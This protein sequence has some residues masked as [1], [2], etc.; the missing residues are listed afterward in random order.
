M[1]I[2]Q[3]TYYAVLELSYKIKGGDK[4]N[5]YI[6]SYVIVEGDRVRNQFGK[7]LTISMGKDKFQRV[8]IDNKYVRCIKIAAYYYGL[9]DDVFATDVFVIPIDGRPY[10]TQ[11]YNLK[12]VT[13]AEWR[14]WLG[15]KHSVKVQHNDIVY[16]SIHVAM[17][18]ERTSFNKVKKLCE[19][20]ED[21]WKYL[22]TVEST[23]TNSVPGYTSTSIKI[24]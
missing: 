17:L 19:K 16:D 5:K 9:I 22:V 15:Y 3:L 1:K 14:R 20:E 7:A 13:R 18:A 4:M 21:G 12:V 23:P 6:G 24:D 10:N 2:S 11:K 8:Q